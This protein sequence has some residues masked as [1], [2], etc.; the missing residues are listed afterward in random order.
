MII[1]I[2]IDLILLDA[3]NCNQLCVYDKLHTSSYQLTW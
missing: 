3:I 1:A 2:K